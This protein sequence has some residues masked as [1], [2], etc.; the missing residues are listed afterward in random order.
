MTTNKIRTSVE[1]YPGQAKK[2]QKIAKALGYVQK[3]GV[4]K[5]SVGSIAQLMQAI[6]EGKVN[7]EN[8]PSESSP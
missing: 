6:A 7:L 5:G 2:L 3:R 8:V 4:G 1:L